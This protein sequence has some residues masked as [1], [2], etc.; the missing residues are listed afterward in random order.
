MPEQITPEQELEEDKQAWEQRRQR[1]PGLQA[2][3]ER[4][5]RSGISMRSLADT[6]E[7]LADKLEAMENLF[8]IP[9]GADPVG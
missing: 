7:A 5:G 1:S 3:E 9:D 4:R 6:L 2:L 8:N